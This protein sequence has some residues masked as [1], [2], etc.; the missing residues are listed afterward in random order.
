MKVIYFLTPVFS[1]QWIRRKGRWEYT[2]NYWDAPPSGK[3]E[4]ARQV[5]I[6]G[7]YRPGL[8]MHN[9]NALYSLSWEDRFTSN[10]I[11]V[12]WGFFSSAD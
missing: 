5:N 1:D 11:H 6:C 3:H 2:R 9:V 10:L 7:I 4:D 12:G 8:H